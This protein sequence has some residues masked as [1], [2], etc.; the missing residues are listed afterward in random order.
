MMGDP[1]NDL[2]QAVIVGKIK[3]VR[4]LLDAGADVNAK[5]GDGWTALIQ[6][7]MRG[8]TEIV[9]M[10]LKKGADVNA[11]NIHGNTALQ[12]ASNK[13]HTDIVELLKTYIKHKNLRDAR[14]VTAKG[15][16][17]DGTPLLPQA[18]RDV[19]TMVARFMGG[20]R[21]TRRSKKSKRKTRKSRRK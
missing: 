14:L 1:N 7:S 19:A 12:L 15:T 10:L 11:K 5:S 17:E 18:H 20:K 6:A 4:I 9:A 21:K 13:G 8:H 3:N 2:L 16:K